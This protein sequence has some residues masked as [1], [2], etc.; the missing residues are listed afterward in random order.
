MFTDLGISELDIDALIDQAIAEGEIQSGV[1]L[2]QVIARNPGVKITIDLCVAESTSSRSPLWGPDEDR[3]VAESYIYYTDAEVGAAIGRSENAVKLRRQRHLNLQGVSR[4]DDLVTAQ[5]MAHI[6]GTDSHTALKL[7]DRDLIPGW[8]YGDRNIRLTHKVTLYR[9][10]VNPMNWIYFINSVRDTQRITDRHLRR[11]IERQS[12]RWNDEWW[13][14]GQVADHHGV[15]HT[16]VNRYI[17]AGKLASIKWGNHWIL[18]SEALKPGLI[19]FKTKGGGAGYDWNEEADCFILVGR[20]LG[21]ERAVLARMVRWPIKRL[22]YRLAV[23]H[24]QNNIPDLIGKYGLEIDYDQLTGEMSAEW[25][26]Y[27]YM[28]PRVK[29]G[30][31][32]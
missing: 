10:A 6:L 16:D 23:L 8:S 27:G 30:N 14:P 4:R 19:F 15:E 32:G 28:F 12:E 29:G 13:T 5:G 31:C 17:Q 9:W 1:P 22:D 25:G 26:R 2:E 21:V 3:F 20:A 24:R 7:F 11:L 18:K